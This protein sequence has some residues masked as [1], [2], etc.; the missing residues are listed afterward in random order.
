MDRRRQGYQIYAVFK[1]RFIV[2]T[3]VKR[4]FECF[5]FGG[6]ENITFPVAAVPALLRNLVFVHHVDSFEL[7]KVLVVL[8]LELL[9]I[10]FWSG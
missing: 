4:L 2:L 3:V 9:Q 7:L 6:F 1:K 5:S 8:N 10:P